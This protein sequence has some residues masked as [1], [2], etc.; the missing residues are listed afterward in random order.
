METKNLKTIPKISVKI[1]RPIIEKLDAKLVQS[2]LRRDAYLAKVLE[3]ELERLD[4]EVS[5]PNS[6][7]SYDFVFERLDQF[8]RKLVSLALPPRLTTRLNEIC[9]RKRIVRDAFFNR[10]FLLLAVSPQ[11]VDKLLFG[12]SGSSWREEVWSANKHDGPFFQNGFYPLEPWIDPF[13]AIRNGLEICAEFAGLTDYVEPTT[14]KL[15]R[16]QY[17]EAGL[18]APLDGLYTTIF[19]QKVH[20]NDLL[21]FSCYLPDWRI[22]GHGAEREYRAKLDELLAGLEAI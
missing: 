3:V 20:G 14:G 1:W 7:A 9:S 8:D 6:P 12:D 22:P 13:W 2:C 18:P 16:V 15:I 11:V 19:E 10:I 5:I 4:E 21:G 17:D